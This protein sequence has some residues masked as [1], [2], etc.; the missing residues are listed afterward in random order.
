MVEGNKIH[1]ELFEGEA[2]D[3]AVQEAVDMAGTECYIQMI[4][5]SFAPFGLDCVDQLGSVFEMLSLSYTVQPSCNV[6]VTSG[7]GFLF[8]VNQDG[9]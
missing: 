4:G 5:Q 6:V 3:V 7:K 1:D 2:V 8:I 9:S